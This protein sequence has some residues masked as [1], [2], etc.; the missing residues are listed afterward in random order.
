[1]WVKLPEPLFS[2]DILKLLPIVT[3]VAD[4]VGVVAVG[5]DTWKLIVDVPTVL[6]PFLVVQV[7]TIVPFV[8]LLQ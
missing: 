1:L 4:K 2:T 6:V 7:M 8:A 3:D 5:T